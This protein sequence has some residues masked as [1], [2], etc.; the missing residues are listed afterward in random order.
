LIL[1]QIRKPF[2]K[3]NNR[4]LTVRVP[5]LKTTHFILRFCLIEKKLDN[6][7]ERKLYELP[8]LK[9]VDI[10]ENEKSAVE[11]LLRSYHDVRLNRQ[12]LTK[13]I[14]KDSVLRGLEKRISLTAKSVSE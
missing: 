3:T 1:G 12:E 5:Q 6:W 13:V 7:L 2:F 9:A 14:K 11:Q 8:A 4:T 10:S